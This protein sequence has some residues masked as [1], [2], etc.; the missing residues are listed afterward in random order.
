MP[1]RSECV[2][3]EVKAIDLLIEGVDPFS[4]EGIAERDVN[5]VANVQKASN[6]L[7]E[8]IETIEK[9]LFSRDSYTKSFLGLGL[10][11]AFL[12]LGLAFFFF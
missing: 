1:C 6:E 2:K 8:V 12:F 10:G 11:L 3:H 9:S 5:M 4:L 7:K